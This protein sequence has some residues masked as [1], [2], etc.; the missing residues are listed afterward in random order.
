MKYFLV[1]LESIRCRLAEAELVRD[2]LRRRHQ[3][4]AGDVLFRRGASRRRHVRPPLL[5]PLIIKSLVV[6]E[7]CKD[8]RGEPGQENKQISRY[9]VGQP[10]QLSWDRT[11]GTEQISQEAQV[12]I[13]RTGQQGKV[14]CGQ[15]FSDKTAGTVQLR[16]YT[17]REFIR[18]SRTMT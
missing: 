12:M 9:I 11:A 8:N 17:A 4:F 14:T 5:G 3:Y 2:R 6:N 7:P 15:E 13:A 16:Q 18:Y 1:F 10:G